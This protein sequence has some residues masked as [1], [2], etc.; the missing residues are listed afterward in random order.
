LLST[1]DTTG[2][3]FGIDYVSEE[4]GPITFNV[5]LVQVQEGQ[6]SIK[7]NARIPKGYPYMKEYEATLANYGTYQELHDVPVHYVA[8]D[9]KLVQTLLQAYQQVTGDYTS[10][11]VTIGGGT[12][13]RMFPHAV[14]FGAMLPGREDVAHRVDEHMVLDDL[15]TAI[16]VYI[17]ALLDLAT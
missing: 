9:S 1:I 13:A 10:P 17:Q 2:K 15:F 16:E 11:P 12:Y 8:K 7:I 5:G 6:F 4:M 3:A 14:A